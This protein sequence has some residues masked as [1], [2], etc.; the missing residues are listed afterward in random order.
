MYTD[1]IISEVSNRGE[2]FDEEK[3]ADS[4]ISSARAGLSSKE[5]IE[6]SH[7]AASE[8]VG[9]SEFKDDIALLCLKLK[10]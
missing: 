1:G 9:H 8:F 5:I 6:A 7:N 10:Q 2:I 3:L 4:V